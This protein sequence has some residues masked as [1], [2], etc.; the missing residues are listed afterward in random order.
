MKFKFRY[1]PDQKVSLLVSF[2]LSGLIIGF[3]FFTP[4][5]IML[6]IFFV[7]P[8]IIAGWY[9]GIRWALIISVIL[10]LARFLIAIFI[11]PLWSVNF[12]VINAISRIVVLSIVSFIAAKLSYSIKQIKV[13]EGLT[14]ICANCKKIRDQNQEWQPLEKYITE[15][16]EAQFTHGICPDC[17]KLLY[18]DHK[19]NLD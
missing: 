14:P 19:K 6:S 13:L 12:N 3:D 5:Q 9:N 17:L 11:E 10:P 16:S 4:P 1:H 18:G 2:L 8:V 15:R 7:L